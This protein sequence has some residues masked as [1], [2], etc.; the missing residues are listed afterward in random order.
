MDKAIA[1]AIAQVLGEETARL[2][3]A[4]A[5]AFDQQGELASQVKALQVAREQDS[6]VLLD[7]MGEEVRKA[8]ATHRAEF[9]DIVLA[10]AASLDA[11]IARATERLAMLR[12]GE[13]GEKGDPGERGMPGPQGDPGR[14]ADPSLVAAK[15]LADEQARAMLR[16]PQG[17]QGERGDPGAPG[18]KGDPGERGVDG[19]RGSQG[20]PGRDGVDLARLG[21]VHRSWDFAREFPAGECLHFEGTTY[22]AKRVAYGDPFT[23][24]DSWEERA[25]GVTAVEVSGSDRKLAFKQTLGRGDERVSEVALPIPIMRGVWTEGVEYEPHDLVTKD[26]ALWRCL[27]ATSAE[28]PGED[29]QLAVGRG[30]AGKPGPRGEKGDPGIGITHVTVADA[31]LVIEMSDGSVADVDLVPAVKS[32]YDALLPQPVSGRWP[33]RRFAGDYSE[34]NAYEAG[35]IVS[36]GRVLYLCTAAAPRNHS[37]LS[38]QY[39]QVLFAAPQGAGPGMGGGDVSELTARVHALERGIGDLSHLH[40]KG[41]LEKIINDLEKRVAQLEAAGG[42]GTPPPTPASIFMPVDNYGGGFVRARWIAGDYPTEDLLDGQPHRIGFELATVAG[43]GGALIADTDTLATGT[44]N[45]GLWFDAGGSLG[46][47]IGST[48]GDIS[49]TALANYITTH[50]VLTAVYAATD[51]AHPTLTITKIETPPGP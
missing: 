1:A 26:G 49:R 29:W 23:D 16:G 37:L 43:P 27:R 35:D 10:R 28:P 36:T 12:D 34:N 45:G 22:Q 32:I 14:D 15:L 44:F 46:K 51:P 21:T 5:R 8:V 18:Q 47:I 40:V 31:G 33:V 9:A 38:D 50:A 3:A 11:L 25:V 2:D 13:R 30:K 24:P 48:G 41:S 6:E 7:L 17:P 4:I 39:W 42:G 20:E 19:L